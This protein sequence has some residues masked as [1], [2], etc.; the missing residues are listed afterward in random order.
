LIATS[1]SFLTLLTD[2]CQILWYIM[3]SP[4][5]YQQTVDYFKKNQFFRQPSSFFFFNQHMLPCLQPDGKIINDSAGSIAFAPNGNGGMYHALR[6][7]GALDDMARRGIEYV[8]QYCVDNPLIRVAD[9]VFLGFMHETGSECA[10]KVVS[11]ACSE[12]PVGV[13]CLADGK[14]GVIEYSEIDPSL[15]N[16]VDPVTKELMYN[17]AHICINNFSRKFLQRVSD[18]HLNDLRLV[19]IIDCSCSYHLPGTTLP[20][21]RFPSPTPMEEPPC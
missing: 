4:T 5:T 20:K 6:S 11:K 9:P 14:P 7:S 21:R 19:L 3:T 17:Y 16:A 1:I 2:S 15:R 13:M 10:A 8:A 12:E 18:N